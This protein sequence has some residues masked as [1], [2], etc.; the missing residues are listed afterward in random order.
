MNRQ[1]AKARASRFTMCYHGARIDDTCRRSK[2]QAVLSASSIWPKDGKVDLESALPLLDKSKKGGTSAHSEW[3]REKAKG[4]RY[5]TK[6]RELR[7]R[8]EHGRVQQD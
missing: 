7:Y 4:E 1:A 3:L 5:I 2:H 8:R 6:L